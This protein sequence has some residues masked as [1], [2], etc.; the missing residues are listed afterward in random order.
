[1]NAQ[2]KQPCL[3]YTQAY[4]QLGQIILDVESEYRGPQNWRAF[5]EY[6][7]KEHAG[8]FVDYV[9]ARTDWP[10]IAADYLISPKEILAC[11]ESPENFRALVD[12]ALFQHFQN[13]LEDWDECVEEIWK[14]ERR[15]GAG[16]DPMTIHKDQLESDM[17]NTRAA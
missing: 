1:M 2:T 4:N 17:S 8:R 11:C 5:S 3:T 10:S 14:A 16:P 12:A 15:R 6:L 13:R 7:A 9:K